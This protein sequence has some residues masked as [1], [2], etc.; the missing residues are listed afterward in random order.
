MANF[1]NFAINNKGNE[2]VKFHFSKF[3]TEFDEQKG[4]GNYTLISIKYLL[5]K[6]T[7]ILYKER[8]AL[9]GNVDTDETNERNRFLTD[10]ETDTR[11]KG[12]DYLYV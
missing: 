6:I 4:I 5:T 10:V 11:L 8:D 1:R 3:A 12:T 7:K 2:I 9:I